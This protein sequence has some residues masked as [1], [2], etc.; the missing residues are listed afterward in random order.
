MEFLWD[1]FFSAVH[2]SLKLYVLLHQCYDIML[3]KIYQKYYCEPII[4]IFFI[5]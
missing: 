4:V 1:T 2:L 5:V 3:R